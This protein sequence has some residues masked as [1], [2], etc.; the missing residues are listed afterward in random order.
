M[1]GIKR[2]DGIEIKY[3]K[4]ISHKKLDVSILPNMPTILVAPNGFGKSS[5]AA[6]FS[7]LTPSKLD[8]ADDNVHD[9]STASDAEISIS[10]TLEDGTSETRVA[11]SK[12]N[13]LSGR[14]DIYVITSRLIPKARVFK[15][16]GRSIATSSIEI[17][18][19][20][21]VDKIPAKALIS[22][23]YKDV[24]AEFG[25][26]GKILPNIAPLLLNHDVM[27]RI[28]HQD[29]SKENQKGFSSIINGFKSYVN[30]ISGTTAQIT[31][32]IEGGKLEEIRKV[33]YIEAI[34][35]IL[36]DS[37]T[38]LNAVEIYCA[39]IQICTL[40][41][42]NHREFQAA[43]KHHEYM[44]EKE[45]FIADLKPFKAT[46]KNISPRE[47]NGSLVLGFPKATQISNGER[48]TLCLVGALVKAKRKIKSGNAIVIIDEVFDYL[49]DANLIA[50]Q[51]HLTSMI[52]SW[53]KEGRVLFPLILTHLDPSYF[54][55]FTFKNQKVIYLARSGKAPPKDVETLIIERDNPVIKDNVSK[56]FLHFHP[57]ECDLSLE[58]PGLGISNKIA[59]SVQFNAYVLDQL[60]RYLSDKNYDPISVCCAVRNLVEKKAFEKLDIEGRERFVSVHKTSEKLKFAQDNGVDIPDE[61]FLLSIIYNEAA[62]LHKGG[63][64][65]TP[66]FSKLDNLTIRHMIKRIMN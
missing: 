19:I 4:G 35:T 43:R 5:L 23:S 41:K 53:K 56:F 3:I 62:H 32:A 27:S 12:V 9:G 59:T 15:I 42:N 37:V 6:G 30:S 13:E 8:I 60:N 17:S 26:N 39:A 20:N 57:D 22:Y 44:V 16:S 65:L 25:S 66:L 49:D 38:H 28:C 54:R 14:F 24:K 61:Y 40:H 10:Y 51:Y 55:N 48:D 58:F 47:V 1:S 50:C 18:D 29:F 21:L 36:R 31:A 45:S 33:P 46:W 7:A 34:A 63:D 64:K 52:A 2:I 11:N